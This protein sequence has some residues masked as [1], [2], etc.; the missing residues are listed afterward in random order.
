MAVAASWRPCRS[1]A[2]VLEILER[3]YRLYRHVAT[4]GSLR[5]LDILGEYIDLKIV[6]IPTGT[7]CFTWKIPPA[8]RLLTC[9]V[10]Q[11]DRQFLC[12]ADHPLAVQPYSVSFSGEIDREEL[13]QHLIWSEKR[14]D[15]YAY[16]SQL[17][18]Q[19]DT[20][21]DWLLS[22]PWS[23]VRDLPEGRYQVEL[24]TEFHDGTMPV[25]EAFLPGDSPTTIMLVAHLCHPG[26]ADDGLSGIAT[27]IRILQALAAK[28]RRRYSYLLLMPVETIGSIG[29][30]W[31]RRRLLPNLATGIVLESLGN[32][33][34]LAWKRSYPADTLL[35]RVA[36]HVARRHGV[37]DERGF[38]DK[39]GND[40]LVFGD[41][42]FAVPMI[43]LQR[44]P[45]AEYHTSDDSPAALRP[46]H[47]DQSFQVAMDIIDILEADS[48]PKRRFVGPVHLSRHGLYVDPKVN[49][50]LYVQVWT[51]MQNLGTGLSVFE[52][53][54]AT[55]LDFRDVQSYLDQ[56]RA[57]GLIDDQPCSPRQ[58]FPPPSR[59][60][61]D[62]G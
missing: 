19:V 23:K 58:C 33:Q 55:G 18:Y 4:E 6:R 31:A 62:G 32:S 21:Q 56:W 28:P 42:D 22:M 11:G 15:A 43:S 60:W 5:A 57:K 13:L 35:D 27:G 53:A 24:K 8:W 7:E 61:L 16:K 41:P 51:L 2:D 44:W 20:R 34:P 59:P 37:Q 29:W 36:A 30:L 52:M 54:E 17:A 38:R 47:L 25:G 1:S 46:E 26:I 49:R 10:R 48:I 12:H 14:P 39:V 9:T 45:Y 50:E 3:T 40:E